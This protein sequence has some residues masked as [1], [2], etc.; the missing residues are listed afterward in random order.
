[1]PSNIPVIQSNR[2]KQ[3]TYHKPKQQVMYVLLN[4]K[5]RKLSVRKLV[6]LLKQTVVNT[7]A[8]LSIKAHPQADAPS[9]YV[10]KKKICSLSLRIQRSCSFHSLALNVNINLSPF[11]RI[12]PCKYAKIKIAKISQ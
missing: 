11:L 12:N 6:T 2:S 9:V 10:K 3:V 8:K 1:M 4:L 7:L 5:R